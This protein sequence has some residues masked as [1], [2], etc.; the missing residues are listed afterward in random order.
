MSPRFPP[1]VAFEPCI[2]WGLPSRSPLGPRWWSLTPPFHPDHSATCAAWAV[3]FLLH[4]P[5]ASHLFSCRVTRN[6]FARRP[7]VSWHPALRCPDFPHLAAR[8]RP[9]PSGGSVAFSSTKV[10][11]LPTR[12]PVLNS[13]GCLGEVPEWLN[14]AVSK[15]VEPRKGFRGFESHPLRQKK[16]R[17]M[18][19][20]YLS[21]LGKHTVRKPNNPIRP[22][23]QTI[24]VGHNHHCRLLEVCKLQQQA[25][26]LFGV[27]AV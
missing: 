20:F 25:V 14:G 13:H 9:F 5:S 3:Y 15:T 7:A 2:G 23:C 26:N 4:F 8:P 21:L 27:V 6:W 22:L 11:P 18:R 10:N 12:S 24:V 1:L 16:E 19:S 17:I